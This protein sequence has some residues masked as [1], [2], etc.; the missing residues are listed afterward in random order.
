MR[1]QSFFMLMTIQPF[2]CASSYSDCVNM[3]TLVAG[4]PCVGTYAYFRNQSEL[5]SDSEEW[6]M[7]NHLRPEC[8][9]H[10]CDACSFQKY[11]TV[12]GQPSIE[13]FCLVAHVLI[14]P[15]SDWNRPQQ[16]DQI[17]RIRQQH[18]PNGLHGN[19]RWNR[20]CTWRTVHLA[21]AS[22]LIPTRC[23]GIHCR[24]KA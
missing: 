4:S 23:G 18:I 6:Y 13:Y 5:I 9:T 7:M 20:A 19:I 11:A 22:S 15:C 10:G 3:P 2:F 12:S 17:I 8:G 1:C 16:I 14:L 21:R 24:C